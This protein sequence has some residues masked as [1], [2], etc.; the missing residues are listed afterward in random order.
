MKKEFL[1]TIALVVNM[2]TYAQTNL[3]LNGKWKF[4]YAPNEH[5][6]DSL[7]QKGFYK[8]DFQAND[9]HEITV[10]S[11]WAI[12]GYEEPVYRTWKDEPQSEGFYIKKFYCPQNFNNKRLLMHFGGIWSS[13]EIWING[14]WVGRHDSGYTSFSYD[15]SKY[16][17]INE[18]NM[19]IMDI[20]K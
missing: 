16:I 9:F 7:F 20:N 15:V 5:S 12:L 1:L 13:A 4:Y 11:C 18:E 3:S 10:P 2:A 19:E 6:A 14:M 8:S 17:K